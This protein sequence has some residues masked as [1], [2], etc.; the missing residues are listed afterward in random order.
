MTDLI[1]QKIIRSA[2]SV[3]KPIFLFKC[4]THELIKQYKNLSDISDHIGVSIRKL[5]Y[6]LS[7][8]ESFVFNKA[9][10]YIRY[11]DTPL[12]KTFH[13]GRPVVVTKHT[14][15]ELRFNSVS[16]A[17]RALKKSYNCINNILKG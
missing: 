6:S 1:I 16:E 9:R 4:N 15:E 7:Y 14:R 17:S 2:E 3:D 5:C 11:N 10:H 8:N 13:H 12:S